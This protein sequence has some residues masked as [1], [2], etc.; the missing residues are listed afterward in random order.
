M[1]N[2]QVLA[3]VAGVVTRLLEVPLRRQGL[4]EA[5]GLLTEL[6]VVVDVTAVHQ[7]GARRTAA[8]RRDIPVDE[9]RAALG[10][11]LE[12]LRHLGERVGPHVVEVQHD[13]VRASRGL[14]DFD[15]VAV[16]VTVG[17][18][19]GSVVSVGWR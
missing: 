4:V 10:H 8:G 11:P 14:G 12:G 15:V 6:P 18:T 5:D 7:V 9:A 2:S 1:G 13:D 17:V 3:G 19:V 16:L